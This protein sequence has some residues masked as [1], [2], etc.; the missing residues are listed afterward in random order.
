MNFSGQVDSTKWYFDDEGAL[1]LDEM[2][3]KGAGSKLKMDVIQLE[4]NILKLRFT[5]DGLTS[6]VT[7]EPQKK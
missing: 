4:D 2:K 6:T 5:E 3:M 1:I 7:F